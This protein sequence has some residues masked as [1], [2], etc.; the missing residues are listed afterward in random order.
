MN[1]ART[2]GLDA[3]ASVTPEL[4]YDD[5][6]TGLGRWWPS[7]AALAGSQSAVYEYLA[8]IYHAVP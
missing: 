6:R 4:R 8:Q 5:G 7:F 1:L 2:A 3:V